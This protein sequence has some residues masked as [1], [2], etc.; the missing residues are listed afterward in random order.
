M[1]A[2]VKKTDMAAGAEVNAIGA[3]LA[4]IRDKLD[5][6]YKRA[7]AQSL[8]DEA[9]AA[10]QMEA[11]AV[12]TLDLTRAEWSKKESAIAAAVAEAE[13]SLRNT[14]AQIRSDLMSWNC[15][16]FVLSFVARAIRSDSGPEE[17]NQ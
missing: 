13:N 16:D 5:I 9:A 1:D 14:L 7:Q 6:E 4:D 8:Q 2:A 10:S 15:D 3:E 11:M 12:R 17:G